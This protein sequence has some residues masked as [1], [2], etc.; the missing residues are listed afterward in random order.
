LLELAGHACTSPALGAFAGQKR[1]EWEVG[2]A[3]VSQF[4]SPNL[5]ASSPILRAIETNSLGIMTIVMVFCS[6]PTYVIIC[7][8][9]SSRAA[10]FCMII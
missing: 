2:I 1:G 7:M 5:L 4:L 3:P 10:G 9:L 8:R 6:A